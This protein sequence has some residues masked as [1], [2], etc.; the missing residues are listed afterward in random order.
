MLV[1]LSAEEYRRLRWRQYV[2]QEGRCGDCGKPVPFGMFHFHHATGRGI[3]G[4]YR[5]DLDED[6]YGV[7]EKCHPEADRNRKTKFK[8]Q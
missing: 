8:P 1:K 5:N 7:C 2:W 3:G 6:N 4:G